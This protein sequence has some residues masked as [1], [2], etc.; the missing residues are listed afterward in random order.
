M[1]S[2][3]SEHW[4]AG[5]VVSRLETLSNGDTTKSCGC[6]LYEVLSTL[7]KG[8]SKINWII[9]NF[10][11]FGFFPNFNPNSSILIGWNPEDLDLKLRC[12]EWS[13]VVQCALGTLPITRNLC[14][15]SYCVIHCL[16][17]FRKCWLMHFLGAKLPP[18]RFP[19]Q[20]CHFLN[21]LQ[22]NF[23]SKFK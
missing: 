5:K 22:P 15:I 19:P 23:R 14:D 18:N 3:S 8:I 21:I 11:I 12:E 20:W 16:V 6:Q 2:D 13:S 9:S 4:V 17:R 10:W 7:L 1:P